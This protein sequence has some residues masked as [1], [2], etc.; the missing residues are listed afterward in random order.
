MATEKSS[1]PVN[2]ILG[3]SNLNRDQK[4]IFKAAI[5]AAAED[6]KSNKAPR[7]Y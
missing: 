6:L 5:K 4:V 2:V 7:Y 3:A 1:P